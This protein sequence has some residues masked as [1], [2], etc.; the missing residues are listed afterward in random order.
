MRFNKK[1]KE[2]LSEI[3]QSYDEIIAAN[4]MISPG[5]EFQG[6]ICQQ[7]KVFDIINDI[8]M[9]MFPT[10]IR[11]GISIGKIDTDIL[12]NNAL[13]IAGPAYYNARKSI[14]ILNERKKVTKKY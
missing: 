4:F 11:F 7:E 3:N 14:S 12:K 10:K 5:D 9:N 8:E 6:L 1:L 13:E 2:V